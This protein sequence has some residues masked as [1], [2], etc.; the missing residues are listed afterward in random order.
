MCD[1]EKYLGEDQ[2]VR[3]VLDCLKAQVPSALQTY[4]KHLLDKLS[5]Y[6][7]EGCQPEEEVLFALSM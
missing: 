7:S 5:Q 6:T 1:L 3:S 4:R 2:D